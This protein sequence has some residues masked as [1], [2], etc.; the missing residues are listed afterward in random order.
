ML[1]HP[2]YTLW[3][4]SYVAIGATLAPRFDGGRLVATLVAFFLA[5]GV[6]AHALD[7]LHGR[8]LRTA[9]PGWLLVGAATVSLAGAVALGYRRAGARRA[10]LAVFIVVGVALTVGYNL[11]LLGGRLHNDVTFAAAWGAFPVLTAYYAQAETLRLPALTA[12]AAAYWLSTAQ[13]SLS[14]PAR[15]LRRRVASV[16]GTV[17]Y[18]DGRTAPLSTSTLLATSRGGPQD[19]GVGSDR[20]RRRPRRLPDHRRLTNDNRYPTALMLLAVGGGAVRRSRSGHERGARRAATG[21]VGLARSVVATGL[22]TSLTFRRHD[23]ARDGTGSGQS[24]RGGASW[25]RQQVAVTSPCC[26]GGPG[27]RQPARTWTRRRRPVTPAPSMPS[28]RH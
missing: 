18:D 25:V 15:T 12:A 22:H 13:R 27:S 9:I 28:W 3:H 24:W 4:L 2:P 19:D 1:L 20:P 16:D 10:G 21:I 23:G 14:T 17:T 11:E 7:E 26:S 8:P 6:C 5:V